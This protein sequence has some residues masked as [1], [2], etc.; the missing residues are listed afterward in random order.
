MEG[1]WCGEKYRPQAKSSW[2][3]QMSDYFN[4]AVEED[5]KQNY[6]K[7]IEFYER[8]ILDRDKRTEI[9]INLS[10][11]YWIIGSKFYFRD[12]HKIP[13][14]IVSSFIYNY[15]KTIENGLSLHPDSLEMIF[16]QKYF[17]HRL[18]S[19]DL[20]IISITSSYERSSK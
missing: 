3:F 13:D 20:F 5:I 2:V 12:Y 19:F 6:L 16:W 1:W 4:L 15:E 8:A 10:F 9:Y 17:F 18:F 7:A 11:L 14:K